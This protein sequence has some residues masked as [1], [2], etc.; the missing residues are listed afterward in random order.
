M[1]VIIFAPPQPDLALQPH[2][3]ATMINAFDRP[4]LAHT[5]DGLRQVIEGADGGIEGFWFIGHSGPS[6]IVANNQTLSPAVIG[7]Y[8]STAGV[9]WSYFSSCES[10]AFIQQ[11]QAVY[12]HDA[13]AYIVEV[14]DLPAWRTA[15]LIAA[16]Y[17]NVGNIHQ[18]V[19][20]G[21][22]ANSTALRF[23]P[24]GTGDEGE[25]SQK[26]LDQVEMLSQQLTELEKVLI[27]DQWHRQDGLIETVR[28][29]QRDVDSMRLWFRVGVVGL[30]AN[31]AV[32]LAVLV[33]LMIA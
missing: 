26:E 7:Q 10:A 32:M 20:A 9:Q 14:A 5:E 27:G 12:S 24:N 22:P 17:A 25:M 28:T 2:E 33:R 29:L 30:F 16:K 31:V 21:A 4:L 23:F 13:Y 6:G 8:L 15:A 19:R 3:V 11:V 1:S 18:A